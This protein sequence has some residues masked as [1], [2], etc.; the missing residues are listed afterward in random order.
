MA[1]GEDPARHSGLGAAR[2]EIP[3][4]KP[5]ISRHKAPQGPAEAE[6]D[7]EGDRRIG[8]VGLPRMAPI[9]RRACAGGTPEQQIQPS[10]ETEECLSRREKY[11][12]HAYVNTPCTHVRQGWLVLCRSDA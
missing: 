4:P 7:T 8:T 2:G 6:A 1:R 5:E 10:S 11:G 12:H 3:T 9:R